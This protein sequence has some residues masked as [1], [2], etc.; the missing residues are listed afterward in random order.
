LAK[1]S[2]DAVA[3]TRIIGKS[4]VLSAHCSWGAWF[5]KILSFRKDAERGYDIRLLENPLFL[6][7]E[8]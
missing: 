1:R 5:G 8:A 3:V 2:R 4:S 6:M 7:E